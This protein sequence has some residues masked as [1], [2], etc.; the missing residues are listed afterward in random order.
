MKWLLWVIAVTAS[1]QDLVVD[2]TVFDTQEAC[3]AA[4]SKVQDVNN[5]AIWSDARV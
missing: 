5:T 2:K 1:G 4:A 3:S